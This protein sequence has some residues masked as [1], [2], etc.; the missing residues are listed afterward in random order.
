MPNPVLGVSWRGCS[1]SCRIR[2]AG[3]H[4]D[5]GPGGVP[6]VRGHRPGADRSHRLYRHQYSGREPDH[7]LDHGSADAAEYRG[8]VRRLVFWWYLWGIPGALL[9]V[10]IMATIKIACDHIDTLAPIGEFLAEEDPTRCPMRG[11]MRPGR[12]PYGYRTWVMEAI[13]LEIDWSRYDSTAWMLG[14]GRLVSRLVLHASRNRAIALGNRVFLPD[15]CEGDLGVLAHELTHCAQYQAWGPGVYFARGM[16]S[17]LRHLIHRTLRV[18]SSPYSYQ[19]KPGKP[20]RSYG[21]EQQAQMVEDR[22]RQ[23]RPA[24][25]PYHQPDLPAGVPRGQASCL[26]RGR[27]R[28]RRGRPP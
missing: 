2:G 19:V 22:F 3:E 16:I 11:K 6:D 13:P 9:A 21:M 4:H 28:F 20:F 17:Q 1:I 25:I 12:M 18:G 14:R 5:P 10:P 26:P 8:G 15:R 7:A 24:I 23:A 27:A